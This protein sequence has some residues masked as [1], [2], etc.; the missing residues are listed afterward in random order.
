MPSAR[1]KGFV[2]PAL[3]TVRRAEDNGRPAEGGD[4]GDAGRAALRGVVREV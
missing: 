2:A 4:G 1:R 3:F